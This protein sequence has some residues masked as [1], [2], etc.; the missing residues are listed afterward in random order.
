VY[1]GA[2]ATLALVQALGDAGIPA[3]LWVLTRGAVSVGDTDPLTSPAQA[4]VWGLG[5]VAALEHPSRW[6]GL[7]D[8]PA[9][10]DQQTGTRLCGI[11]AGAAGENA[12][13]NA[14]GNAR[15][16][17]EEN[18]GEDQAAVRATGVF[19]RRLVHAPR[20]QEPARQWKPRG[21]VLVTGGTGERGGHVACWLARCG[22]GHV[23]LASRR[24]SQASGAGALA[25][26]LAELGAR[27]TVSACDV[28]DKGAAAALLDRI[29][30]AGPPLTA[31]VHAAGVEQLTALPDTG[32]PEFTAAAGARAAGAAHLDE[33]TREADLDAFVLFSSASGVWGGGGQSAYAA[34][35]AFMD[36]LAC[37]RRARGQAA[38]S[39]AWGAWARGKMAGTE[40]GV[41]LRRRGLRPMAPELAVAALRQ[42][43]EHDETQLTIADLDWERFIPVFTSARP[44]PLLSD[45]PEVRNQRNQRK[46]GDPDW[47]RRLAGLSRP[48]QEH[49]VLDLIL[50]ETTAVLG[51]DSADFVQAD[52]SV[53]DMGMQSMTAV[54]L[55]GRLVERTGLELPAGFIYRL[56]TP[57]AIADYL[58]TELVEISTKEV[59]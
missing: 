17:A 18:A 40:R 43:V 49:L 59:L 56:G 8:L 1:A 58:L 52:K 44:S 19:I 57:A 2:A 15:E 24:G 36:A 28:A 41:Q 32:L 39:I 3:P 13:G 16:D 12:R 31:V 4:Q 53:Y 14:R 50:A 5:R 37:Q 10:L 45:L 20:P 42:A 7:V 34:A 46:T 26:R 38:A 47:S 9:E 11:L 6:G 48:E 27:V 30:A 22:A 51:Y 29:A 54:E 25:A 33:L 55:R 23:V 35:S 21:T